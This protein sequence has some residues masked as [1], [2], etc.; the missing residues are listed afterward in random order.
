[1][2]I[3][4]SPRIKRCDMTPPSVVLARL[5]HA[6]GHTPDRLF[7][8]GPVRPPAMILAPDRSGQNC[9]WGQYGA[10]KPKS[11]AATSPLL[12]HR[13]SSWRVAAFSVRLLGRTNWN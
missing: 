2:T 8:I 5:G 12:T 3:A 4:T 7:A 13:L 1:M 10:G 11:L 9:L 6:K